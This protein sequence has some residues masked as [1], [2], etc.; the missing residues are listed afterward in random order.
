V[1]DDHR[2]LAGDRSSSITTR[3]AQGPAVYDNPES[4]DRGWRT[5][6]SNAIRFSSAN[7]VLTVASRSG[8]IVLSHEGRLALFS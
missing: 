2:L 6:L 7:S 8:Y 1:V 4:L 3:I 5:C